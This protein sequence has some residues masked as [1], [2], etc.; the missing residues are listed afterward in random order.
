ML[1]LLTALALSCSE[2]PANPPAQSEVQGDSGSTNDGAGADGT[3]AS[4]AFVDAT[5]SGDVASAPD[6]E[7]GAQKCNGHAKLC[8]RTLDKVVFPSTHN[9]MSNKADGWHFPNQNKNLS[10]QLKDGIRG[11]LIDTH[12]HT[13]VL[14]P[15]TTSWLCHSSCLLGSIK[16]V[17]ALTIFSDFLAAHPNEVLIFV[18]Q[19]AL[20]TA[21]FVT[22]MKASGL[23]KYVYTHKQG[24]SFPT[25]AKMIAANTRLLVTTENKGGPPGWVH[26]F[27][28]VGFDTP[29]SFKS[30]EQ[31]QTSSGAKDSCKKFRGTD[32]APVFLMNHWVASVLP[33]VTWSTK[34]NDKAVILKRAKRCGDKH[35]RLPTLIAVDHYDIGGL[36]EAVDE[37]NGL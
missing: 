4:D 20:T 13:D 1:L 14:H 26:R 6:T 28:D 35:G 27:A 9:A 22:E 11:F 33:D 17:D 2:D 16:L 5:A 19:D 24:A 7:H 10:S 37:L 15:K 12:K 36:F 8:G 32:G 31:L 23:D 3:Q 18:V 21:D 30:M 29:Y 25:L 34:A